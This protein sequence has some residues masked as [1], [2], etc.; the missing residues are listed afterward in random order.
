[1]IVLDCS[2]SELELCR[3]A[4]NH[5]DGLTG[6]ASLDL[7]EKLCLGHCNL[8]RLLSLLLAARYEGQQCCSDKYNLLHVCLIN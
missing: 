2:T 1:M 6:P 3:C 7:V 5:T 4:V 8:C